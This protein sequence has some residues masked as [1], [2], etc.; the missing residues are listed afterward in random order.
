MKLADFDFELPET[1][2]AQTPARPRD[3]AR[4]LAVRPQGLD[5]LGV[6]DLPTLL[7]PGD[8]MVVNDT[9]VLPAR[10]I[11]RRGEA[12]AEATLTK[13]VGPGRW[14]AFARPGRRLR[15]GDRIDFAP[16]FGC[17]L[18]EK[19]EGGEVELAFD[20]AGADLMAA[21]HRHGSPPL[22][23]YI[24]RP[25]G[26]LPEDDDDYQT[27][28]AAKDGAV[29]APTASLHFTEAL[30]AAIDARGVRR[31]TVTLHVGAGTFLPVKTDDVG[32]H[33]MHA[34]WGEVTAEAADAIADARAAGGRIVAIGTTAL[35]ILETSAAADSHVRP[36]AGETDI[37]IRP[38]YRFRAVDALLT[39]FHLP[40]ST[41]FMLVSAM[42][43]LPEMRAAYA[44]AVRQGY[45]FFSYG[46][47]CLLLP[48]W[49]DRP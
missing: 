11:G 46:D 33:P 24:K 41:L 35:R 2:I 23:P 15:I 38:G 12:K 40:K 27:P 3:A 26:A 42:M 20:V 47:A 19:L 37:F 10:L 34:E 5:D 1:L 31:A 36:F 16:D 6:A 7:N 14:R 4:L 32:D 49:S 13:E 18:T 45:R 43:G 22:P 21:L 17:T 25:D 28:F 8:L 30:L 39:N 44:H 9:R 48:E 29:A